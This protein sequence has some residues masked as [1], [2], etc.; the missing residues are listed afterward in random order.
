MNKFLFHC[1]FVSC[2][3]LTFYACVKKDL[4]AVSSYQS[5]VNESKNHGDIS[6]SEILIELGEPKP[7]HY[8]ARIDA[9]SAR[10]GEELIRFGKFSDGS[11]KRISKYFVCTDCHNQVMQSAD[12]ADE[13]PQAVIEYGI[14][15]KIPFLPASSFYGM[16]NKESWY[17]GDYQKKYGELVIPARDTLYQ[18][19]QLCAT[20][21]SQGRLLDSVEV[22]CILHYFKELEYKIAD[23]VFKPTEIDLLKKAILHDHVLARE[24]I[25]SKYIETNDATFGTS[26]IPVIDGYQANMKNAEYIYEYGC[27]HC[28]S[29]ERGITNFDLDTSALSFRFLDRKMY[30]YNSFSIS[31][32]TRY[33]TY[34]MSGRK[35]YMP[36][37]TLEKMSNEHLLDL[38]AYIQKKAESKN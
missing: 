15:N 29:P 6:V 32:I 31:H 9:D 37:Y 24:I 1:L 3:S 27:L 14:Q 7:L 22:R 38:I 17:N 4:G 16:Y 35:Q 5:S 26:E 28:H 33:G 23:L 10:L 12:P 13:S 21:C 8:I 30:Q 18:A 36:Q 11:N 25:H 20:A 34:A 19:I 2:L